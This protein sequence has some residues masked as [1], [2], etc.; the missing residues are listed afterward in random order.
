MSPHVTRTMAWCALAALYVATLA[1]P[2][3]G[4]PAEL[5][6]MGPRPRALE[7]AIGEKKFDD[8]LPIAIELGRMHPDDALVAYWTALVYRGLNRA[9][10]EAA[11]WETYLAQSSMPGAACP[12]IAQAYARA[13]DG[14]ASLRSL[15]RCALLEPGEAERQL[16]LGDG[17][18]AAGDRDAALGAYARGLE[19]DPHHPVLAARLGRAVDSRVRR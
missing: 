8:A 4:S 9:G 3:T 7:R 18:D 14:A 10:D 19:I 16:D 5:D 11:A 2:T 15:E 13:G 12:A 1:G 6:A 17:L